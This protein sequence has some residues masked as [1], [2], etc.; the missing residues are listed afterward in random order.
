MDERRRSIQIGVYF[1]GQNHGYRLAWRELGMKNSGEQEILVVVE[2][3]FLFLR[4]EKIAIPGMLR[5]DRGLSALQIERSGV[6]ERGDADAMFDRRDSHAPLVG[7][8][9][10]VGCGMKIAVVDQRF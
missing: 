9:A 8:R 3:A 6:I 5:F 10:G 2:T 4:I 7:R 1:S